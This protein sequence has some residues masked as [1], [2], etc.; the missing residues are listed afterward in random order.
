[1]I[2]NIS[3]VFGFNFKFIRN[4]DKNNYKVRKIKSMLCLIMMIILPG[5][6]KGIISNQC[7]F[8]PSF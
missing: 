3:E 5:Y 6:Q 1:M 2:Q 7:L 8:I 4:T